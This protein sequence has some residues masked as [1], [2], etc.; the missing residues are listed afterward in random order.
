MRDLVEAQKLA[1]GIQPQVP[2]LQNV[3]APIDVSF[4]QTVSASLGYT[5][6]PIID[7]I[8]NTIK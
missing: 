4:G 5:Y 1:Q 8:S 7:F 6:S 2:L 3:E